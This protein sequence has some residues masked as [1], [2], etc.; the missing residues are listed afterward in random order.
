MPDWKAL[1]GERLGGLKCTPSQKNE[2]IDEAAGHLQDVYEQS[3]LE[4]LSESEAL[5]RSLEQVADWANFSRQVQRTKHWEE[6][7]NN[8]TR[9][10]WL[11]GCIS[12]LAAMVC[13]AVSIRVGLQPRFVLRGLTTSV[14]YITWL[15]VLPL[16]GAAGAGLSRRAGGQGWSCILAGLFPAISLSGLVAVLLLIGQIVLYKPQSFYFVR[17][18]FFGIVL[19]SAALLL[20]TAPFLRSPKRCEA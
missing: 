20:G 6:T 10:L 1:V 5:H 12:L 7:M 11:P 15:S 14:I 9:I 13:W 8:R 18:V 2:I 19:P 4:G 17:G 3:C 16:C